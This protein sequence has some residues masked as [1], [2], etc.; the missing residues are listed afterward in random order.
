VSALQCLFNARSDERS[1]FDGL[2]MNG[3]LW[4]AVA[5]TL[6]L[7]AAVIYVP[8]LQEAFSSTSLSA[9]D[10]LVCAAVASSVV[11][12]R[13]LSKWI[14]QAAERRQRTSMPWSWATECRS[15]RGRQRSPVIMDRSPRIA[16][17]QP[18]PG[19]SDLP[20]CLFAGR[21]MIGLDAMSFGEHA[22]GP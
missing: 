10:W 9:G 5:L 15:P 13:E 11:W 4:G 3:W 18:G 17:G 7:H 14:T 22:I 2:F 16:P 8:F 20:L 19:G 21:G 6:L 12:V 1:A